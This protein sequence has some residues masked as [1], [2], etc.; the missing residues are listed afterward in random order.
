VPRLVVH[1]SAPQRSAEARHGWMLEPLG[2]WR[3]TA[4]MSR[5]VCGGTASGL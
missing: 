2:A 3:A 5:S 1:E 4:T